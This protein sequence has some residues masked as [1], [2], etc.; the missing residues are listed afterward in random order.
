MLILGGPLH[1]QERPLPE[2]GKSELSVMAPGP[3]GIPTPFKYVVKTIEAETRPGTTFR[4]TFLV[5]PNIP[6]EVA[7]QALG[8]LLLQT[9]AN[10]L[11]RQYMEGG[12]IVNGSNKSGLIVAKN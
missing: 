9:F 11:V 2:D 5:D 12:E 6:L 8:S 7:S 10:E 1:G 4:R 3:N